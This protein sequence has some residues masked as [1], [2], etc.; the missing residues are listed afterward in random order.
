MKSTNHNATKNN[1]ILNLSPEEAEIRRK[2]IEE[3]LVRPKI[4]AL[5]IIVYLLY[6]L[7]VAYCFSYT[8]TDLF[9]LYNNEILVYA[10]SYLFIFYFFAKKAFICLIKIYQRTAPEFLRRSCLCIPTCSDYAIA[11]LNKY[12]LFVA[13]FKIIKRIT[14]TCRNSYKIDEP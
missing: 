13:I 7:I 8:L 9:N 3:P 11:V 4:N 10:L 14:V 5:K 12:N 6:Y 1:Q 2:I